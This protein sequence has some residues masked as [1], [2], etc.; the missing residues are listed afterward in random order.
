MNDSSYSADQLRS[1]L[2]A[3]RDQRF[4]PFISHL[5]RLIAEHS[6]TLVHARDEVIIYRLQGRIVQ[7]RE[8]LDAVESSAGKQI[9]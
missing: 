3:L 9:R 4:K 6:D 8:I 1:V 7:L 2:N 5:E